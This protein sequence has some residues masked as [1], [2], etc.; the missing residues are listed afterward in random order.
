MRKAYL[1]SIVPV[2]VNAILNEHQVVADIVAFVSKGDFPR[3]RLGEKQRGKILASWVTR[4]LRTIA[5]FGIRDPENADSQITEIP[6]ERIS[7][8]PNGSMT[9]TV[10]EVSTSGNDRGFAFYVES[11]HDYAPIP[12]GISEMPA[13]Y[14]SSILESPALQEMSEKIPVDD[15]TPTNSTNNH[16]DMI[17]QQEEKIPVDDFPVDGI[18]ERYSTLEYDPEPT[19][20]IELNRFDYD[21]RPSPPLPRFESKP[22]LSFS[23][24]IGEYENPVSTVPTMSTGGDLWSLPSQQRRSLSPA[25]Q[26]PTR[27][28][29]SASSTNGG[30]LRIANTGTEDEK[31]EWP[32]EAIAHMYA[33]GSQNNN[34][35]KTVKA[36][37]PQRGQT[38]RRYDGSGYGGDF[39]DS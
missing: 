39:Q 22:I 8:I 5:Q 37:V 7:R 21:Q 3:S 15:D 13:D 10:P 16:L 23:S 4:K 9:L 26:P 27:E 17:H 38:Q 2:I 12:S 18:P 11:D 32:R 35:P 33:N 1:A 14:E 19:P 34:N 20:R 36:P 30:A 28:Y 29:G 31:D 24:S 6:E 25:R